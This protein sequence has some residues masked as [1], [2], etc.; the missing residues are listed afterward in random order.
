MVTIDSIKILRI[1]ARVGRSH[2]T[3]ERVYQGKGSGFSR[4][5]VIEAATEL[6]YPLPPEPQRRSPW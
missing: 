1:A 5:A 3:V 6:G 4:A 2:R